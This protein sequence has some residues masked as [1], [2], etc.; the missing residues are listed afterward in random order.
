MTQIEIIMDGGRQITGW[1]HELSFI[2]ESGV[3][4]DGTLS[5]NEH[6]GY[7]WNGDYLPLTSDV[8]AFIYALDE[9]ATANSSG[10]AESRC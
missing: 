2:D 10:T 6:D 9:A 3:Q 5:W 8:T 1:Q 7:Q 4:Y